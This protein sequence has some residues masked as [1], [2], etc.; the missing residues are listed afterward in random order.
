MTI[1]I[2]QFH[3]FTMFL[4]GVFLVFHRTCL[5]FA[6]VW[7][8][9]NVIIF[10]GALLCVNDWTD[11]FTLTKVCTKVSTAPMDDLAG[12]I[13]KIQENGKIVWIILT[14][15]PLQLM[16]GK[17]WPYLYWV[18]RFLR[19]FFFKSLTVSLVTLKRGYTSKIT[20]ILPQVLLDT[21]LSTMGK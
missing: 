15:G 21:I 7:S 20:S 14:C 12:L 13:T 18:I 19:Y 10:K 16:E 8:F 2:R 17:N 9:G 4:V 6:R 11:K 5:I 3:I 1:G